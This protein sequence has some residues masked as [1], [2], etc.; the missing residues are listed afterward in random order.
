MLVKFRYKNHRG[1]VEDREVNVTSLDY[2]PVPNPEY[3]YGPGWFLTGYDHS[4]GRDGSQ[5]R[6]FALTNI[7]LPLDSF[8]EPGNNKPVRFVLG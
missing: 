7:Q 6:S 8:I 1:E 4:R 2:C 3:G 5:F